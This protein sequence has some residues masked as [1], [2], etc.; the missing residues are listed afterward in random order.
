MTKKETKDLISTISDGNV[1]C[2]AREEL[3]KPIGVE[4]TL[5][6]QALDNIADGQEPKLRKEKIHHFC[7]INTEC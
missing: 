7:L 2:A 6:E 1:V 3:K 5:A 4:E